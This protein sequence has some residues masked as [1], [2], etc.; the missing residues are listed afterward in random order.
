MNKYLLTIENRGKNL[1]FEAQ[2]AVFSKAV[3]PIRGRESGLASLMITKEA[4]N[5][6]SGEL[7]LIA[8]HLIPIRKITI[9]IEQSAGQARSTRN[10]ATVFD[11]LLTDIGMN[12]IEGKNRETLIFEFD[13]RSVNFG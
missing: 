10:F 3:S 11:A 2:N 12:Q 6:A 8:T 5:R 1:K 7:V 9:G 4:N 13:P